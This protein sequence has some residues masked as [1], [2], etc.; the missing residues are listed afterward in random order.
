M[1]PTIITKIKKILS[2]SADSLNKYIPSNAVVEAPIPVHTAYAVPMGK[3]S[4]DLAS[5]TILIIS[6]TTVANV[7]LGFVRPSEYS[8]PIAQADSNRP[9]IN[10]TSH[11]IVEDMSA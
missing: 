8:K 4:T 2:I 1:I 6:A 3:I 9:A 11:A 5:R 7:G 10:R